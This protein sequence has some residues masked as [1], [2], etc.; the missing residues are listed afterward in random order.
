M[1]FLTTISGEY[2]STTLNFNASQFVPSEIWVNANGLLMQARSDVER[3]LK[4]TGANNIS[5]VKFNM[6][7]H[8]LGADS[9]LIRVEHHFA[10]PDGGVDNPNNYALSTRFWT[11]SGLLPPG[12]NADAVVFYDGRGQADLLDRP[13]FDATGPAEDNLVLLFRPDATHVWQE[14]G[15]YTRT[16]I[17]TNTDKF[18]QFK[19][20]GVLPGQYTIGKTGIGSGV[21]TIS[22]SLGKVQAYPNPTMD[23]LEIKAENEIRSIQI[24]NSNGVMV[25]MLRLDETAS[26]VISLKSLPV[27]FYWLIVEGKK[28]TCIV[29]VQKQ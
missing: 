10:E 28:G 7:V 15:S 29:S 13:L 27:G 18:G 24:V 2:G 16:N 14:F 19:I 23:E 25:K 26:A 1:N 3:W 21:Q 11:V 20:T 5:E 12:F 9:V 17:G 8:A 6:T 4:T 22:G